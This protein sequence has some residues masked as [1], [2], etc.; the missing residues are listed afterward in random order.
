M[1]AVLAL[2][3]ASLS[4]CSPDTAPTPEPT[5]AFASE[6]EAF[7]AAE[8]VY[9]AYLQ[10]SAARADGNTTADPKQYLSG[11]ALEADIGTQREL[12]SSGIL[13]LG[14]STVASFTALNSELDPTTSTLHADVCVDISASRVV[15]D[16]GVDI[17]PTDRPKF[18]SLSVEFS[19]NARELLI[20]D[21]SPSDTKC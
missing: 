9:R 3:A 6:E 17:T 10:A 19:G 4:A 7:A 8:E 18:G 12:K 5:T 15:D 21:S 20:S 2:A 16:A 1:L 14:E 11:P 13:I